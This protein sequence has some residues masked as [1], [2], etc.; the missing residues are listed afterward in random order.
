VVISND[1]FLISNTSFTYCPRCGNAAL[2]SYMTKG[3]KCV[4][5][6]FIYFHNTASA[7]GAIISTPQGI[8]L[9][10]R[11]YE[12]KAG[13]L[14]TP[15]GFVDYGE[16]LETALSRELSEELN[17]SITEFAYL[18]SFPNTYNYGSVTYYTS[19]VFF[20][21]HY[22]NRKK[23]VPNDEISEIVYVNDIGT[24]PLDKMAFYSTKSALSL[25]KS[26]S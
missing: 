7:V 3:F 18:G 21:C 8:L 24:F 6:Q 17:I 25:L 10:R 5:C 23:P 9:V 11:A 15:G 19:D 26:R 4:K 2:K 13:K 14:D 20:T 12:P 16:Q 22:D 1:D